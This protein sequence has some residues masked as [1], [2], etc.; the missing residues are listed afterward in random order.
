MDEENIKA[1]A[2]LVGFG[3][4]AL[5]GHQRGRQKERKKGKE[6]KQKERK[7]ERKKRKR[8]EKERKNEKKEGARKEKIKVSQHDER[9]AIQ[10]QALAGAQGEENFRGAKL[11][12]KKR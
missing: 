10:F 6:N 3:G 4:Q 2:Y 11:T 12:A 7:N 5:R 8:R 9:G 1:G